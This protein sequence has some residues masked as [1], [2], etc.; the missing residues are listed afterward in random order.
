MRRPERSVM[1]LAARKSRSCAGRVVGSRSSGP[2][3]TPSINAASATDRV[4]GPVTP[5][6][7]MPQGKS[8]G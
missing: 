5:V 7:S 8:V 6:T 2:A 3:I 1:L 4:I